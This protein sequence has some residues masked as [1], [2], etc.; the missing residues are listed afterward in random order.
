MKR[1][2]AYVI[3]TSPRS[4]STLLC[5]LLREAADAGYPESHFHEPSLDSW[6]D[7]HGL[8]A[9]DF[10]TRRDA[11][12]AVFDAAY[13]KGKG[14]SDIFG[15]RLQRHSFEFFAQ[16]LGSLYPAVV[17][18]AGRMEAAFG[19]TLFIHLTRENKLEQ[20]ISYVRAKQSGLWHKAPDGSEIERLSPARAPEYDGPEIKR[21]LVAFQQMDREWR[22]WFEKEKIT[23]LRLTYQGLSAAPYAT[24]GRVLQ[25]LGVE[26]G[27][28]KETTPPVAK[29][30]DSTNREW[31]ER[32]M[33]ETDL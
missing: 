30:A 10:S 23:P 3:C 13:R 6:L 31:A 20:A 17:S 14:S 29:L 11:L 27:P 9:S 24:L 4:G 12:A 25:A 32:Y 16:K 33:A 21:Q 2:Q 18:D 5:H 1:F 7:D 15:L 22:D 28:Q 26:A 8:S 19:K